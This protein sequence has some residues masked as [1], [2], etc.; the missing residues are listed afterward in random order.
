[1]MIVKGKSRYLI[2]L[3][4]RNKIDREN[5]YEQ[6]RYLQLRKIRIKEAEIDSLVRQLEDNK[7][8]QAIYEPTPPKKRMSLKEKHDSIIGASKLSE[9]MNEC[10]NLC[11]QIEK[12]KRE[13]GAMV[14]T[15]HHIYKRS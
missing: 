9:L 5:K 12:K 10:D 14:I 6:K 2:E 15:L 3:M 8:E 7:E 1:M 13:L 11:L 4:K